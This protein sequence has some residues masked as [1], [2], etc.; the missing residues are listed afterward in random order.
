MFIRRNPSHIADVLS[1]H[2][3]MGLALA[4]QGRYGEAVEQFQ[5]ALKV[6]AANPDLH[7][8]LAFILLQQKDFAGAIRHYEEYLKSRPPNP[9]VMN[10]LAQA[11]AGLAAADSGQR[12][13]P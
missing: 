2:N 11:R 6:D 4:Q 12:T 7:G 3:L 5:L 10:N 9:F 8:N 1:A 13:E